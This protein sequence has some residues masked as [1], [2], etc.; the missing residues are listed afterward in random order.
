MIAIIPAIGEELLF[1][2]VIQRLFINWTKNAHW[3]ILITSILFSALH[4][5]FFG[6]FPRMMLGI[7]FGYLFLW[8]GSLWLPILCHFINNGSAVVY[9]Y[10]E[11]RGLMG[12][13]SDTLGA[14][15]QDMLITIACSIAISGLLYLIYKKGK[16]RQTI[17]V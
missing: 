11:Q 16:E 7:L 12:F 17:Q 2:G 5:Q 6:F 14:E 9:V 1:R 4:M 15:N 13:S 3:G 8:S 10:L